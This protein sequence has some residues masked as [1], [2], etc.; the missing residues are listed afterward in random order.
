MTTTTVL[1][2]CG[3]FTARRNI[4]I[5]A[6]NVLKSAAISSPA[7]CGQQYDTAAAA[8]A[9]AA[10]AT[11]TTAAVTTTTITLCSRLNVSQIYSSMST[12][13][14]VLAALLLIVAS[15]FP[16]NTNA[17]PRRM[18]GRH[19]ILPHHH[20]VH[21][22]SAGQE[23]HPP[24][25][26]VKASNCTNPNMSV[27]QEQIS[28]AIQV[29]E[30]TRHV[31]LELLEKWLR[32]HMNLSDEPAAAARYALHFLQL[33]HPL[34]DEANNTDYDGTDTQ[35]PDIELPKIYASLSIVHHLME[36]VCQNLTR[37]VYDNYFKFIVEK[38]NHNKHV[39]FSMLNLPES[40]DVVPDYS[41]NK[42]HDLLE[43]AVVKESLKILHVIEKKYKVMLENLSQAQIVG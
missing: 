30:Q 35:S 25:H 38:I 24:Q 27:T 41:Y 43:Y 29:S 14:W 20:H 16:A 13:Y 39:A 9:A 36:I 1:S 15:S 7:S 12:N 10:T 40:C 33:E 32:I 42:E 5:Q 19:L 34:K 8:A 28:K 22:R 37:N 23:H 11:N 6:R 18:H 21:L 26:L 3:G 17:L 31:I 4:H 2:A